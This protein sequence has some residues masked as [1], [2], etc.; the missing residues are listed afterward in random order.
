MGSRLAMTKF[1]TASRAAA[2]SSVEGHEG[3]PSLGPER[4]RRPGG[5]RKRTVEKDAALVDDL[6]RLVEPTT[7]GDPESP[8][9]WTSK[10][11]RHLATE[12]QAMGHAVS[13]R[14]VK[15]LLHAAGYSLQAN[16]KTREGPQ[17]PDRDAQFRYLNDQVRRFQR[18][19]RPTISVDTKK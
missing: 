6:D 15:D 14:L 8:L 4:T 18:Q 11:V 19:H 5:G 12:L 7:S 3:K 1:R 10:S 2:F 16:R 9:R 13:Y 17:H